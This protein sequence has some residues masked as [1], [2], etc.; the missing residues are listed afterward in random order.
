MCYPTFK[1]GNVKCR[2][3]YWPVQYIARSSHLCN[4]QNLSASR[5]AL[6]SWVR[7]TQTRVAQVS[8]SVCSSIEITCYVSHAY[9]TAAKTEFLTSST[10][11]WTADQMVTTI[12][13]DIKHFWKVFSRFHHEPLQKHSETFQRLCMDTWLWTNG[14]GKVPATTLREVLPQAD[15]T[16]LF[17]CIAAMYKRNCTKG[18]WLTFVTAENTYYVTLFSYFTYF[19]VPIHRST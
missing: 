17:L 15:N 12:Q 19:F 5:V 13:T 9:K 14:C 8:K 4:M 10:V 18:K 3:L 2:T 1:M 7:L 16:T 11:F 6:N